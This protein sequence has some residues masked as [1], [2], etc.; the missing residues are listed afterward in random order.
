MCPSLGPAPEG[1]THG[2]LLAQN[3]N[4]P[5]QMFPDSG[6]LQ[7]LCSWW[8]LLHCSL[9]LASG[10]KRWRSDLKER[11]LCEQQTLLPVVSPGDPFTC[12]YSCVWQ[13][14]CLHAASPVLVKFSQGFWKSSWPSRANAV[15]KCTAQALFLFV[16]TWAQNSLQGRGQACL[17]PKCWPGHWARKS[18]KCY[19]SPGQD[20]LG[21][22]LSEVSKDSC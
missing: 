18:K 3:W 1:P 19:S 8:A 15:R 4:G 10:S 6:L 9:L 13:G 2:N 22:I 7:A 20:L 12:T 16:P 14:H 17:V 11:S 5:F 21:L